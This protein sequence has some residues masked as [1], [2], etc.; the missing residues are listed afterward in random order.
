MPCSVASQSTLSSEHVRVWDTSGLK[1]AFAVLHCSCND[2]A[3]NMTNGRLDAMDRRTH[4]G[5]VLHTSLPLHSII[6]ARVLLGPGNCPMMS[7]CKEA[8]GDIRNLLRTKYV[9]T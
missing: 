7:L 3:S 2:V 1:S 6:A 4:K 8:V 5:E 9:S